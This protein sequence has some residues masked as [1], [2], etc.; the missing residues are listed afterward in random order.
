MFADVSN[1]LSV[2]RGCCS[3]L[4]CPSGAAVSLQRPA[5]L[6]PHLSLQR[7]QHW[8]KFQL[9]DLTSLRAGTAA[10]RWEMSRK[11]SPSN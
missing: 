5:R 8:A 9:V 10:V 11:Q 7:A 1:L 6:G 2:H 3:Y 4:T